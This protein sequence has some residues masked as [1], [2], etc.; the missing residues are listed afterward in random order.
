MFNEFIEDAKKTLPDETY[1]CLDEKYF[2]VF[3]ETCKNTKIQ[4]LTKIILLN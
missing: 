1:I 4:K 3:C 2:I